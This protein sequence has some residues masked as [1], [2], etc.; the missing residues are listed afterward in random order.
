MQTASSCGDTERV[1][2]RLLLAMSLI[3]EQKERRGEKHLLR[4]A[5]RDPVGLVLA[6]VA[7]VPVELGDLR[8]V[9]V[10]TLAATAALRMWPI[11]INGVDVA[12]DGSCRSTLA[13]VP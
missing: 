5:R 10:I 6:S 9:T 4:L 11:R 8:Q 12:M 1:V 13:N 7:W 3:I 2:L